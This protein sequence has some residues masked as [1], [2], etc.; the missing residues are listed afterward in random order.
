MESD[1]DRVKNQHLAYAEARGHNA[2]YCPS[3]VAISCFPMNWREKMEFVREVADELVLEGLIVV[4][5]KG[6]IITI[7]ASDARGPIR[8]QK[9]M[10]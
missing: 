7:M 4:K 5:Q 8:L 3:E 10:E 1:F 9:K 2:T 6:K